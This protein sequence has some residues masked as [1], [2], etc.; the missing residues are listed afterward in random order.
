MP[1]WERRY[2]RFAMRWMAGPRVRAV[3]GHDAEE[4]LHRQWDGAALATH[5]NTLLAEVLTAARNTS[6]YPSAAGDSTLRA[7][8][9]VAE[10]AHLAVLPRAELRS[11]AV[12]LANTTLPA[13]D[14]DV[15]F[16]SGTQ[17]AASHVLR[18][19]SSLRHRAVCEHRWY[20][21]LG[22]PSVFEITCATPWSGEGRD[23]IVVRDPRVGYREQNLDAFLERLN[24]GRPVGEL[25][26]V[27]PDMVPTL[28]RRV[29]DWGEIRSIASS[30]ELLRPEH[31]R[32]WRPEFPPLTQMYCAAEISVPLA[33]AFPGCAGM[34]VN[35]DYLHLEVVDDNGT[36]QGYGRA[37]RLAVTDL[38]NTA[39]PLLRYL[40]GDAAILRPPSD[41]GCGRVLPL[42]DVLGRLPDTDRI[43]MPGLLTAAAAATEHGF[44]LEHRDEATAVLHVDRRDDADRIAAALRTETATRTVDIRPLADPLMG[45]ARP[46]GRVLSVAARHPYRE[47]TTATMPNRLRAVHD[48]PGPSSTEPRSPRSIARRLLRERYRAADITTEISI[49]DASRSMSPLFGADTRVTV[50]WGAPDPAAAVGTVALV[51]LPQDI[52]AAHRIADWRIG[53]DGAEILQCADNYDRGNPYSAFWIPLDGVLGTV[54]AARTTRRARTTTVHLTGTAARRLGRIVAASDRVV[55]AA[56]R[57]H[58]PLAA[59]LAALLIQRVTFRATNRLLRLAGGS[60]H[61]LERGDRQS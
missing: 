43:P 59:I 3:G 24:S 27:G 7:I 34:H 30:F 61:R 13:H 58:L 52:L 10:L 18:S 25:L 15:T 21:E 46:Q 12:D 49:L 11:G 35:A 47:G 32:D 53:T 8:G 36:S 54:V 16:T 55:I 45:L 14:M 40:I 2:R 44:V 38:V 23:N 39:M 60:A 50:A 19:R 17:G 9:D 51:E 29:T 33:F 41:C 48:M 26:I 31:T 42:V 56:Q 4:A 1:P 20:R 57:R 6:Y 28:A 22:L 5:R 37:G